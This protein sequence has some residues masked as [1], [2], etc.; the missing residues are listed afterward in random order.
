MTFF[1]DADGSFSAE[2]LRQIA[3]GDLDEVAPFI[4]IFSPGDFYE[5]TILVECLH[6]LIA[7]RRGLLVVD[8]INRLYR[9]A[10]TSLERATALSKELNRQLAYI[11]QTVTDHHM[12][13][14]LTSHVR[15]ILSD[16]LLIEKIEPVAAR[17][18]QYWATD[19]IYLKSSAVPHIKLAFLEK[20]GGRRLSHPPYCHLRLSEGGLEAV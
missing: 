16:D 17:T 3:A 12:P 6:R 14:L 2:R 8:S 19:I 7:G 9:L 10:I 15:S 4:G 20:H 1:I 13:V 18:L 11:T 5:Q